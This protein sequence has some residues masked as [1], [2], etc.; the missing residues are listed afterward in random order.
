VMTG[1]S[2]L[3]DDKDPVDPCVR[4]A[5]LLDSLGVPM[6]TVKP[7]LPTRFDRP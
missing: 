3:F 4:C 7:G 5:Q 2:P 1:G 6:R